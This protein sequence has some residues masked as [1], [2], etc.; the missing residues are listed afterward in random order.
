MEAKSSDDDFKFIID[1]ETNKQVPIQSA[2][3]TQIIKN[4]LEC[5]KNGPDSKNIIS[6]KMFYKPKS[7]P[8][9]ATVSTNEPYELAKKISDTQYDLNKIYDKS[10]QN[11]SSI[12]KGSTIYVKRSSGK[13]QRAIVYQAYKKN[14]EYFLNAYLNAGNGKVGSKKDLSL[15]NIVIG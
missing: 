15:K 14:N 2:I 3:G 7:K 11:T 8:T 12:K 5:I 6:T 10:K 1:P 9:K 13:W 4:Y